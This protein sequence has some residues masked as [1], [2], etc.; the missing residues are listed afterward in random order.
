MQDHNK[1]KGK[2][3]ISLIIVLTFMIYEIECKKIT[4]VFD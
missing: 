3:I 1:K 2:I 4:C